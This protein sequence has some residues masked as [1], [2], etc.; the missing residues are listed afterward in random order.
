MVILKTSQDILAMFEL[1][2]LQNCQLPLEQ[3]AEFAFK[4][5]KVSD[6]L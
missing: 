1:N 4:N 5:S 3:P 2:S 6:V